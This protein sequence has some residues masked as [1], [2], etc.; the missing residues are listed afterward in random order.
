MISQFWN[1][2]PGWLRGA[3]SMAG[4]AV[5]GIAK[6]VGGVVQGAIGSVQNEIDYAINSAK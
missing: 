3:L 6:A 5:G 4:D 2:L 1:G